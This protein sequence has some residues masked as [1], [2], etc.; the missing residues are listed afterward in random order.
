MAKAAEQQGWWGRPK[1]VILV[2]CALVA[3]LAGFITNI[4]T[5][6]DALGIGAAAISL[7][8]DGVAPVTV[9]N[10]SARYALS[11]TFTKTGDRPFHDCSFSAWTKGIEVPTTQTVKSFPMPGGTFSQSTIVLVDVPPLTTT[12]DHH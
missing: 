4:K 7:S 3:G 9:Q 11:V 10:L 12:L 5:I 6:A 8:V 2:I 1:A